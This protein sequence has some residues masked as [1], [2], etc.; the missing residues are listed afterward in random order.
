MIQ[1]CPPPNPIRTYFAHLVVKESEEEEEEEE[2]EGKRRRSGKWFW[3]LGGLWVIARLVLSQT[4]AK[5]GAGRESSHE[6]LDPTFHAPG[7]F[8]FCW[9]FTWP[10]TDS[11][12][13][14]Y[15]GGGFSLSTTSLLPPAPSF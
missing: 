8:C 5:S 15:V 3:G 7:I 12:D 9:G 6:V 13:L 10:K 11:V 14:L 4:G 1:R 2:E